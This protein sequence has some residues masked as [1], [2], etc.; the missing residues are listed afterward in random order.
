[1]A[2]PRRT[3][4]CALALLCAAHVFA[5]CGAAPSPQ[6]D[7][8]YRRHDWPAVAQLAQAQPQRTPADNL[9]Y[10]LALAHLQRW[11]Q[12]YEALLAG[13]RACPREERF[14]VELAGVAFQQKHTAQA[15][16]W[17][18][19]ALRL[20]PH[21]DYAND[22]AGTVYYL[23]G[24]LPTALQYWNRVHKPYIGALQFD[25][26]LHVQRLLLDRAFAFAPASLLK[27]NEFET[28]QTRLRGLGIFPAYNIDLS[29]RADGKF[30]ASFHAF[31]R[32]GF[33][34]TRTQALLAIFGGLPYETIYPSYYN[35]H[36]TATNIESLLRWDAQKRRLWLAL[37]S[38]WH[39]LPQ[40]RWQ[41]STDDRSENWIVRSSFTGTAPPLGSLHLNRTTADLALTSFRSGRLQWTTGAELSRRTY[42]HISY[43]SALT[44]SLLASG[45]QL[46]PRFTLNYQLLNA[47]AQRIT[48]TTGATAQLARLW[49][50]PPHLYGKLQGDAL[51]HWLPQPSGDKYEFSQR[52]RGGAILGH[53]PFDELYLIGVERDTDLWLRGLIGTRDGRKGSS[54]LAQR[55]LLS[56]TDVYRRIYSNGLITLHAGPLFDVGRAASANTSLAAPHRLYTAGAEAKITVLGT[57]VLLTY[58]RDLRTGTNAFFATLAK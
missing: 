36:G 2:S 16:T 54:P 22:F 43:G 51:L 52:L 15:A 10:G 25:P 26:Q 24:N 37:S 9:D 46:K 12:A 49:S 13:H 42:S 50:S 32:N 57:S 45:F 48:I 58:G 27:F 40:W 11:P 20:D 4:L 56:N 17:L 31:E 3:G 30:D 5:Q 29:A 38:P 18:R 23:M 28:T 7:A 19:R 8:A 6:I 35:L 53:A 47:P 41:L 44:P 39:S 1:M 55:Y 21:D 33:G 34:N 14:D